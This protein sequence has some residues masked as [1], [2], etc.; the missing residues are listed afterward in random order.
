MTVSY[1]GYNAICGNTHPSPSQPTGDP[2]ICPMTA[3]GWIGQ[4]SPSVGDPTP[5]AWVV[6]FAYLLAASLSAS[7]ARKHFGPNRQL[8]KYWMWVTAFLAFLGINKQLDFQTALFELVRITFRYGSLHET[9]SE[10][11]LLLALSLS[12]A[13]LVGLV[14]LSWLLRKAQ[15]WERFA[16]GGL[17][18]LLLFLVLRISAMGGAA[19]SLSFPFSGDN[20]GWMMELF[21]TFVVAISAYRRLADPPFRKPRRMSLDESQST[22]M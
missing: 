21:G 14:T 11:R 20:R 13:C 4:W 8:G 12:A 10:L 22:K 15:F 7:A 6:T 16:A 9:L 17:S 18:V 1:F 3:S 19:R 2:L 5:M